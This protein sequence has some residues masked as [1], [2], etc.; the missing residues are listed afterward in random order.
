MT[1]FVH[2]VWLA[3][4]LVAGKW[5]TGTV[6]RLLG[7]VAVGGVASWLGHQIVIMERMEAEEEVQR[8]QQQHQQQQRSMQPSSSAKTLES[9]T[10]SD[11]DG[12]SNV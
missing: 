4:A 2:A 5:A 10:S 3:M 12:D 6:T 11:H 8:Q 9:P 1:K 7:F